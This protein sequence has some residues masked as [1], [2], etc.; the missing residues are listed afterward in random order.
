M[1][2]VAELGLRVDASGVARARDELGRFTKQSRQAEDAV[3]ELGDEAQRTGEQIKRSGKKASN[4]YTRVGAAAAAARSHVGSLAAVVGSGLG[5]AGVVRA[6]D[7]YTK[8]SNALEVAGVSASQTAAVEE[9]LFSAANENGVAIS[10]LTSLYQRA[11][12]SAKEL[13]ASQERLLDF[14]DGVTAALRVQG[15]SAQA[16]SGALLQLGQSLGAGTV[17]AEEINSILEGVPIIAMAAADGMDEFNGSVSDLRSAVIEGEV[18]SR[19]FFEGL[20]R[21]FGNLE[22]Q[23]AEMDLTVGAAIQSLG[24]AFIRFAGRFD[25]ATGLS[26]GLV[27]S[28]QALASGLDGLAKI[29]DPLIDAVQTLGVTLSVAFGPAILRGV[30]SL[31]IAIGTGLVGA[32]RALTVAMAA[33]PLGA[34]VVAI[35]AVTTAAWQFRDEIQEAIGVDVEKIFRDT[36][37]EIIA[38]FKTAYDVVVLAWNDLPDAFREIGV[39]SA[40][41]LINGL[42]QNMPAGQIGRMVA[43][44]MGLEFQAPTVD[45]GAAMG[46][47]GREFREEVARI[48]EEN[49]SQ[50]FFG[51]SMADSVLNDLNRDTESRSRE[52]AEERLK[53]LRERTTELR[54]ELTETAD[55]YG[56][57]VQGARSFIAEQRL[58]QAAMGRSTEAAERLRAEY[59][60]FNQAMQAGIELTPSQI[61]E[62]Q[63]LAAAMGEAAAKTEEMDQSLQ[64]ANDNLDFARSS[65]R[66]FLGD[67]VNGFKQGKS[68]VEA[69]ADA[70]SNLA[71]R[72]IN[73]G[74]D[75]L[76]DAIFPYSVSSG[77][78]GG[79]SVGV[80][81]NDNAMAKSAAASVASSAASAASSAATQAAQQVA[82]K[83]APMVET[84]LG[85]AFDGLEA[86]FASNLRQMMNDAATAGHDISVN[87]GFRSM[88][89]QQ[90]L[91][92]G[93]LQKYGDPEIADNFVA[94]PGDS[95]HNFGLAAD[96]GYGSD[97]ARRFAHQNAG[98]YGLNFRMGHEPWHIEPQNGIAMRNQLRD[99]G[100]SLGAPQSGNFGAFDA[101]QQQAQ[102]HQQLSQALRE[103]IAATNEATQVEQTAVQTTERSNT[104]ERSSVATTDQ[105]RAAYQRQQQEM[106]NL[107]STSDRTTQQIQQMG[108]KAGS[109]ATE[110]PFGNAG[111]A[112]EGAAKD[113]EGSATSFS[114]MFGNILQ[115]II[116]G[117]GGMAGGGG[118]GGGLIGS[119][120][121]GVVGLFGAAN[122]AAFGPNGVMA[123]ADGGVV[124]RPT[125]FPMRGGKTGV[126][127]E[128]GEEAI[129]PLK[130]NR[131]GRL[132][133]EADTG[134]SEGGGKAT[135]VV[136]L[137]PSLKSE[138]K[139]EMRGIAVEV[140]KGGLAE[141]DRKQAP[142]TAE[143]IRKDP[144][145]VG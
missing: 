18:S 80:P 31:V 24:N 121:S 10:A 96:L 85:G 125:A 86:S 89:R 58:E 3:D 75:M 120:I 83:A 145:K 97:A 67:I 63:G 132:G 2:D 105:I 25:E 119:L 5:V 59:D 70:L 111:Q 74:L 100:G 54:D 126:M 91:W 30:K 22:D 50:N 46:E 139:S 55:A 27:S 140:V 33:N 20:L 118:G 68:A 29:I 129:L 94:R 77:G 142:R 44:A 45:F 7:A 62:L 14:V 99:A 12:L 115:Q 143:R 138:M 82:A 109:V 101:A 61:A 88:E 42:M 66:G 84:S 76:I 128:A 81:A 106:R 116:G 13:G 123:F 4:A 122:G 36:A 60:L 69:F 110:N 124:S 141:Y 90:Q 130:R 144:R 47:R 117:I 134:Q 137:D 49:R 107:G 51:P 6:T 15:T 71:D 103:Q 73:R 78:G 65:T 98:N 108:N 64:A 135:V 40:E 104:A 21:G 48:A 32:V 11:S 92:E 127:G 133:V 28:I 112:L 87:S 79:G 23:A 8:F 19:E 26:D 16:A 57:I 113:M 52:S 114:S 37:N 34:L 39:A 35:T 53:R 93:A 17:R 41:A 72:I 136:S 131:E 102:Q 95:L 1:A 56:Q 43:G 9:R 38:T